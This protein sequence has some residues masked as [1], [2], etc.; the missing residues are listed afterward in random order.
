MLYHI[1]QERT[2][3]FEGISR[4]LE[5]LACLILEQLRLRIVSRDLPYS[6]QS[7]TLYRLWKIAWQ[8]VRAVIALLY[9]IHFL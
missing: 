9:I 1:L 4:E 3:R 6:L 2:R 5:A 7:V 8:L